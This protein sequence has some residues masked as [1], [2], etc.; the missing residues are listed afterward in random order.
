MRAPPCSARN[1]LF[2]VQSRLDYGPQTT[3]ELNHRTICAIRRQGG[4][5]ARHCHRA[6]GCCQRPCGGLESATASVDLS[7]SGR[8]CCRWPESLWAPPLPWTRASHGVTAT[9]DPSLSGCHRYR[10]PEPLWAPPLPCLKYR[11]VESEGLSA[12]RHSVTTGHSESATRDRNDG[13]QHLDITEQGTYPDGE[14]LQLNW[15]CRGKCDTNG[16]AYERR[17]VLCIK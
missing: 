11:L 16:A 15:T 6:W 2:I 7:L 5:L 3:T 14:H 10:G 1:N 13:R 9:V 12:A 4:P 17:T 8:H